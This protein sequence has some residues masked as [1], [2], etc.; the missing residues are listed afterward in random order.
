M[1][2][3]QA[4]LASIITVLIFTW[5]VGHQFSFFRM[6]IFSPSMYKKDRHKKIVL[7]GDLRVEN[8]VK[9][10]NK[11]NFV[12]KKIFTQNKENNQEEIYFLRKKLAIKYFFFQV[13]LVRIS[14]N[15]SV[16]VTMKV[17]YSFSGIVLKSLCLLLI[18]TIVI[19]L[20]SYTSN[21][22]IQVTFFAY[23]L[24]ISFLFI[25][26]RYMINK[27]NEK[28][29]KISRYIGETILDQP[30]YLV[31]PSQATTQVNPSGPLPRPSQT[32]DSL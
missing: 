8:L 17:Y 19:L 23:C 2:D 12:I 25:C 28:M 27:L 21:L 1:I 29:I 31:W 3:F 4:Y 7:K 9:K 15:Q 24:I 26:I 5:I 30:I 16:E 20:F 6:V 10:S 13:N 14:I 22:S 11:R 18:S 32:N